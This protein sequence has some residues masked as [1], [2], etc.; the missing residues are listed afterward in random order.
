VSVLDGQ[1]VEIHGVGCAGA[2]GFGGGF[3]VRALEPW[4]E[5]IIKQ[6]VQEGLDEA[7]KL[8]MALSRL[9]TPKRIAL[10][11]YSPIQATVEGEPLEIYPFLGSSRLEEPIGR[12]PV[13]LV[14]HGHAHRGQLEGKTQKGVPVYNVSMP[15]LTRTF[16]DRPPLKIV[17]LPTAQPAEVAMV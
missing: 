9:R 16:K 2:K 5:R 14:F 7:M 13:S 11:H 8:E 12:Y 4:G 10:L 1:S 6:F 3:G 17:E 15:L